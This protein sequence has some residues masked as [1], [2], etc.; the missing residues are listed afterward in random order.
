MIYVNDV[1]LIESDE[2][3]LNAV[4]QQI[5]NRF[6]I[7]N[8]DKIHH[9]LNMKM[10]YDCQQQKIH[11]SQRQY[12]Q[13]LLKQYEMKNC[14]SAS[15]LMIFDLKITDDSVKDEQF[16]QK[17][18]ELVDSQQFLTIYT[19]SD[20]AFATGFLECYNNTLTQQCWQMVLHLL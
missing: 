12:I 10:I 17:Y 13:Q 20:I 16:V 11:L 14:Y 7:K 3:D 1:K 2:A 5:V 8:L 6:E 4:H 19:R 18:Q 15:M 9:Y